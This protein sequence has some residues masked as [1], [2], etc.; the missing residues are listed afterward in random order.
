MSPGTAQLADPPQTPWDA[1]VWDGIAQYY[2]WRQFAAESL[3]AG[4]VPLWNPYQFCGT[5]FVANGQSA[6]FYPLSLLFWILPTALAFAWSAWLHLLLAGWF[7]YLFLRRAAGLGRL[8]ALGGA[9]VWQGNSFTI[10]W[11]H[12]PTTLCTLTW[13][14]LVLLLCDRALLTGRMRYALA[15]GCALR[16][17]YLGGHPRLLYVGLLTVAY[18]LTPSLRAACRRRPFALLLTAII[19][20]TVSFGLAAVQLLPHPQLLASHPPHL[21]PRPGQLCRL[22]PALPPAGPVDELP[23]PA[24]PRTPRAWEPISVPRTT[25]S[26]P[27]ISAS[28][29]R[30]RSGPAL[31]VRSW[32]TR[33]LLAGALVAL[34]PRSAPL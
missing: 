19:L 17:G 7:A 14:P 24:P 21:H 32:H 23:S 8:G 16:P 25:P 20:A 30:S 29:S 11:L 22:P 3:R 26:T 13:L 33:F 18:V 2:P 28:S 31:F 27:S 12:L 9:M 15:A 4:H 5:P 6:V 34:L 1:L 10:A